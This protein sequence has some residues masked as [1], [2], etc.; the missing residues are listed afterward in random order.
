MSGLIRKEIRLLLPAWLAALGLTIIP[1]WLVSGYQGSEISVGMTGVLLGVLLMSLVPF[2]Q[3]FSAGT[4]PQLLSQPIARE[5][6]WWVKALVLAVATLMIWTIGIAAIQMLGGPYNGDRDL[7]EALEAGGS[8]AIAAFA[9]GLCMTLFF[10]QIAAA[11]WLTILVPLALLASVTAAMEK[12]LEAPPESSRAETWG[13]GAV[14]VYSLA[15]FFWA[16][17]M[18]L[19]AQ[20]T[21]W[22]GGTILLPRWRGISSRVRANQ[23]T[24]KPVGTL[25]GKELQLHQVS[26]ILGGVLL[27]LHL[28]VILVRKATADTSHAHVL[29]D[30][31]GFSWSLWFGIPFVAGSTAVAEERK[32]GTLENQLCLPVTRRFQFATKLGVALMLGMVLGGLM[33]WLVESL[34]ARFGAPGE[35]PAIGKPNSWEGLEAC[36]LAS[37]GI[38]FVSF[39]ASS[40]T[41]NVLQAMGT[42]V[43]VGIV[44]VM[45]SAW[46]WNG[47]AIPVGY[48]YLW[49]GSLIIHVSLAV[50]IL[51]KLRLSFGNYRSLVVGGSSWWRNGVGMFGLL[52]LIVVC[53]TLVY[54]RAWEWLMPLEPR[55]GRAHLAGPV[56]PRI[57][58]VGRTFARLGEKEMVWGERIF[59]LLPDGRIWAGLNHR[60]VE[61]DEKFSDE[62]SLK[63]AYL[64]V[65][66]NGVIVGN[67]HWVALASDWNHVFGIQ[68]DGSLWKIFSVLGT[69]LDK[70]LE[71]TP[72]PARMGTDH[73]WKSIT[74]GERHFLA[75]KKDGSVWGWGRNDSGQIGRGPLQVTNDFIRIG[76]DSDWVKIFASQATSV[77]VKQ[78]GSVWKW[79][80]LALSTNGPSKTWKRSPWPDPVRWNLRGTDWVEYVE[81]V[82]CDLVLKQDGTLWA[83]GNVR[84]QLFDEQVS[85]SSSGDI[86]EN[87]LFPNGLPVIHFRANPVQIGLATD[88]EHIAL[89]YGTL[90]GLKRDGTIVRHELYGPR[91]MGWGNVQRPSRYSD[92]VAIGMNS[93]A[94]PCLALAADGT[95]CSWESANT[96]RLTEESR[97]LGPTRRPRW[98]AH[99]LP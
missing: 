37:L 39:Y 25:L 17:R 40:M 24:G 13:I 44:I 80:H 97:W 95:I 53:T 54:N 87:A 6:V 86:S 23:R 12:L 59:T 93:W 11:L 27:L 16:R 55:H 5:R 57:C 43:L 33:P 70:T 28:T 81:I 21:H 2:G 65:P 3:E 41:R 46:A 29:Y 34:A 98:T 92:W 4:F 73:D 72:S 42:A 26:L 48:Y 94:N 18:F 58:S 31:L 74:A 14:L 52:A 64:P 76:N 84:E 45:F 19:N 75:L 67:S 91:L 85:D 96:Y 1:L 88:W 66:T 79:G 49:F 83:S 62:R 36:C 51:G 22:T 32:Q 63:I 47:G 61:L 82:G 15:A 7:K 69:N 71:T 60:N 50:L 9:G 90:I 35:F 77:G 89:N 20:D 99:I 68:S 8:L 10:R 38:G 78:D 30:L 56:Q